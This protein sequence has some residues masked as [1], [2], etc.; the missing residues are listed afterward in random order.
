MSMATAALDHLDTE[1]TTTGLTPKKGNVLTEALTPTTETT[2]SKADSGTTGA[3]EEGDVD[4]DDRSIH[5]VTS[6]P[7][8]AADATAMATTTTTMGEPPFEG[9]GA[10]PAQ[11]EAL[12]PPRSTFDWLAYTVSLNY[13]RVCAYSFFIPAFDCIFCLSDDF[14][15]GSN[16]MRSL[17]TEP[18]TKPYT[19]PPQIAGNISVLA[20]N[21]L[22]LVRPRSAHKHHP[23][24]RTLP[25]PPRPTSTRPCDPEYCQH[26]CRVPGT[27][28]DHE[29]VGARTVLVANA[30]FFYAFGGE[31]LGGGEVY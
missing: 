6:E 31:Y 16:I 2:A 7:D 12:I 21:T 17:T 20:N 27:P 10:D 28:P 29:R 15:K 11:A 8:T 3:A 5:F 22:A 9:D 23:R 1:N 13:N 26:V 14:H 19:S 30:G 24:R 4:D 25:A 18:H